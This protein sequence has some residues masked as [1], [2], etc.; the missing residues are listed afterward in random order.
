MN[1]LR[2]Q[3]PL[4]IIARNSLKESVRD[5]LYMIVIFMAIILILLS[6]VLGQMSFAEQTRILANLGVMSIHLTVIGLATFAG[7]FAVSR[8]IE[9]QTFSTVL[10]RPL[11]RG[12]FIIGKA[13]GY[14]FNLLITAVFLTVLLSLLLG[15][16]KMAFNLVGVTLGIALEGMVL[17]SASFFFS[18]FLRSVVS[19]FA[20][21]TLFILGNWLPDLR[22]FAEKSG[23]AAFVVFAEVMNWVTP[24]L[25]HLNWRTFYNIENG[26]PS[27]SMIIGIFHCMSWTF[28][29]L[30]ATNFYFRRKDLV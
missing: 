6:L 19:V 30:L 20:T 7:V 28:L 17:M 14:F 5:R 10:I 26:V 4:F 1:F 23:S 13:M 15:D 22:F 24:N 27:E 21:I 9:K 16:S 29:F 2:S 3:V 25:Y 8:E 18:T 11:S 12:Q